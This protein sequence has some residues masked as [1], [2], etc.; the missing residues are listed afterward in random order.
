MMGVL[1]RALVVGIVIAGVE[2]LHGIVRWRVL[3][4][5]LGA[6][7]A[8][9]VGVLVGVGLNFAVA[10][11]CLPWVVGEGPR[12]WG[13]I[14]AVWLGVMLALDVGFG[15]VYLRYPWSRIARDFDPRQGGYLGLGM[16]ALALTPWAVAMLRGL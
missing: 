10:W 1:I 11:W 9:Q 8:A 12:M 16:L 15:R 7:R 3:N 6:R 14:G 5:P 2:V 4:R 13:A